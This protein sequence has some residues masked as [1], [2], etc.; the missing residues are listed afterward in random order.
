MRGPGFGCK[1]TEGPMFAAMPC[2]LQTAPSKPDNTSSG[3]D[4]P[5]IY[6]ERYHFIR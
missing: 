3:F 6:I 5:F 1:K 2:R 4:T